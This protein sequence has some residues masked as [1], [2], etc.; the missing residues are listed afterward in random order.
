[1]TPLIPSFRQ[2]LK[3]GFRKLRQ[4]SDW[5][6]FAGNDWPDTIMQE[7]VTDRQHAKQGRSIGRWTLR[8]ADGKSLTVYLKRHYKLPRWAGLL[9]MLFPSR[10]WSPGL[11][12][13]TNLQRAARLGLPVPRPVAAAE[14]ARGGKLQGLLAVEELTGMLALHEAVP[15]AH[16]RIEP[17]AF[18]RWKRSLAC[19]LARLSRLMHDRA[20]Y[21]KDL[22][23]CHFYIRESDIATPPDNWRDRVVVIDLHRL[24]THRLT[25]LWWKIK[26]LGQLL[27]S[28]EVIGVTARD[29]LIFW[30]AYTCGRRQPLLEWLVRWKWQLYRRHNLKKRGQGSGVRG[31]TKEDR[32]QRTEDRGQRTEDMIT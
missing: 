18:V 30:K 21:H 28:S 25:S 9:A 14:Y 4:S 20:T 26:D 5:S 17:R 32:G 10:A 24:A 31:Q 29:R 15:L 12:E 3:T 6:R 11:Q 16:S 22:Y 8:D 19:E 27:Y 2:R 1:M 7:E 13:W 23:F